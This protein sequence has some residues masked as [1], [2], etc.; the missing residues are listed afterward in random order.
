MK[1]KDF[2]YNKDTK[3]SNLADVFFLIIVTIISAGY[4]YW[5]FTQWEFY[6]FYY[7][8]YPL[9][10]LAKLLSLRQMEI[11]TRMVRFL[12]GLEKPNPARTIDTLADG[13]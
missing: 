11:I 12:R 13:S 3:E 8:L 5:A 4:V 10:D 2:I 7:Y 9:K 1:F 6:L